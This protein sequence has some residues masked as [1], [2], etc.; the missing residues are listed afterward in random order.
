MSD[1]HF[2]VDGTLIEA[3]AS[4]RSFRRR[5]DDY[6]SKGD[7]GGQPGDFHGKK[8]TNAIHRSTTD[9]DARL[10]M[11]KGKGKEAKLV[12]RGG[13]PC[14]DGQQ[15][16]PGSDFRLT[17]ANGMAERDAALADTWESSTECGG[18]QALRQ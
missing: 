9:P 11:R 7:D 14:T 4:I 16:W 17:E 6:E 12:R 15:T 1:E 10:M 18:W 2:S 8:L 3:A 5:D 13:W